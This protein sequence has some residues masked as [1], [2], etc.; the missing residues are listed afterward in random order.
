MDAVG[1]NLVMFSAGQEQGFGVQR[2]AVGEI[3]VV[4]LH[5]GQEQSVQVQ[6][7]AFDEYFVVL[8]DRGLEICGRAA[9][10]LAL[11]MALNICSCICFKSLKSKKGP[12]F[13][14]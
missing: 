13:P 8:L 5:G 9:A 7:L 14:K 4:L 10:A 12:D 1:E 2:E 3:S 11:G 6:S